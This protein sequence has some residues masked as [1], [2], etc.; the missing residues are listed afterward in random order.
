[1]LHN[2]G[3]RISDYEIASLFK[4]AYV[5]ASSADKGETGFVARRA[6]VN[7]SATMRCQGWWHDED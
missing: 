6:F 4:T 1:M 5:S 3:K 7:V 2:P